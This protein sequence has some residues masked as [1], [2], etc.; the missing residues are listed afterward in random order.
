LIGVCRICFNSE[1]KRQK[2]P[3][4]ILLSQQE[5]N[6]PFGILFHF[7]IFL[8]PASCCILLYPA[9]SCVLHVPV[10]YCILFLRQFQQFRTLQ[11]QVKSLSI[12]FFTSN[13]RYPMFPF[14]CD[15]QTEHGISSRYN[16][17]LEFQREMHGNARNQVTFL[18]KL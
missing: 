18:G 15:A 1:R 7:R 11:S 10:S 17:L 3:L 14:S 6:T 4:Y 13:P 16:R 2:W 9:A 12:G 5:G 8:R